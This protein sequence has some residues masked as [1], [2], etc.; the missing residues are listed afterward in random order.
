MIEKDLNKL[1]KEAEPIDKEGISIA[2]AMVRELKWS[3]ETLHRNS[4]LRALRE[5]E[6][7]EE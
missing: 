1:L 4:V 7:E 5:I 3:V 2:I 6:A